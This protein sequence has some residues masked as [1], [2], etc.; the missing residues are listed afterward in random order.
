[1]L[2]ITIKNCPSNNIYTTI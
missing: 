2:I 1:M